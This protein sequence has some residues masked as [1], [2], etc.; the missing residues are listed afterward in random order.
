[1]TFH[2]CLPAAVPFLL[3]SV[4]GFT[5]R[6]LNLVEL[7][8]KAPNGE[9][10]G[11]PEDPVCEGQADLSS[12]SKFACLFLGGC[13]SLLLFLSQIKH[14]IYHTFQIRQCQWEGYLCHC[15][16]KGTVINL[17]PN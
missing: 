12:S 4:R 11:S 16:K 14:S 7:N 1:M 6:Y 3:Y 13:L 9:T 15:L 10:N 5:T 2:V 17:T 8:V